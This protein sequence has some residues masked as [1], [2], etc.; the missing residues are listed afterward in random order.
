MILEGF[1]RLVRG[2]GVP[3]GMTWGPGEN[4]E[5]YFWLEKYKTSDDINLNTYLSNETLMFK[6]QKLINVK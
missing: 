6:S 2:A 5:H 1:F 4:T 3:R